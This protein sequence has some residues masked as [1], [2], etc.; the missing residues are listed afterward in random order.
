MR[1]TAIGVVIVIIL[2]MLAGCGSEKKG[3]EVSD[4]V[5]VAYFNQAD[6][7]EVARYEKIYEKYLGV[8]VNLVCFDSSGE[9]NK[10]LA[11][12]SIDIA[13]IGAPATASGISSGI[14]YNV[15]AI[16]NVI[17]QSEALIV[18]NNSGVLNFSEL[19][20]KT[21]ATPFS[22]TSHY[23]LIQALK[24]NGVDPADVD[25]VDMGADDIYAAWM[26]GD[27]DGAYTWDPGLA[28]LKADGGI[29]LID[30]EQ[31]TEMGYP[32]ANIMVVRSEFA[33]KHPDVVVG[34]CRLLLYVDDLYRNDKDRVVKEIASGMGLSEEDALLQL[35]GGIYLSGEEQISKEYL[36]TKD[37]P[38]NICNVLKN[39]AD[40][41]VEQKYL[42]KAAD[43]QV[44]KDHVTGEYM[45]KAL[46]EK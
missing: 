26:R 31:L 32:V 29:V 23:A 9:L 17:G 42:D 35:D 2:L 3:K 37:E 30:S 36:G 13:H 14:E 28:Q 22:T 11:S 39:M 7:Q 43:I 20:G 15:F 27:I 21:I 12:G 18:R 25:I 16:A 34:Y 1:R 6:L 41:M 10:A 33:E 46:G 8:D 24:L 5:N 44:L 45:Q 4:I 40:F 19:V 38:G